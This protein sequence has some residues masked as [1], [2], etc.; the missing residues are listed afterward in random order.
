MTRVHEGTL[1]GTESLLIAD[2]PEWFQT[3]SQDPRWK[4][5]DPARY[6]ASV[7]KAFPGIDLNLEAH[8]AYE[9]LQTAKGQRKKILRGFWTNWLKNATKRP[10]S[11]GRHGLESLP[12]A[13]ELKEGWGSHGVSW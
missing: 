5:G 8:A 6:V 9:W 13:A 4:G 3:L 10:S 2:L 12:T 1:E 11:N 7:A